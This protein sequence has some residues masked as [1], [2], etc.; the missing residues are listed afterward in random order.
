MVQTVAVAAEIRLPAKPTCVRTSAEVALIE[1]ARARLQA[2]SH[3]LGKVSCDYHRGALRLR[4]EVPTYYLKQVAQS[5]L[6]SVSGDHRIQNE[7]IV[8]G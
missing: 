1:R 7:L 5:L 3:R 4:G 8:S 6:L 2:D